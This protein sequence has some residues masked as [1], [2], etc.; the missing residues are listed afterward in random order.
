MHIFV[1]D[2]TFYELIV[3]VDFLHETD[4][5]CRRNGHLVRTPLALPLNDYEVPSEYSLHSYP[6]VWKDSKYVVLIPFFCCAGS[7]D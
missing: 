2:C 6:N 3:D 5:D 7:I 4:V 1:V